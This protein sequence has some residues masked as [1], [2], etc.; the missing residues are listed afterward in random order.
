LDGK[1]AKKKSF[2]LFI[3][4]LLKILLKIYLFLFSYL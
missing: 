4:F 1:A 2:N 3:K